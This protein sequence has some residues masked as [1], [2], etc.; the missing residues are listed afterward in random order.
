MITAPISLDE[1]HTHLETVMRDLPTDRTEQERRMYVAGVIDT[2]QETQTI[3]EGDRDAL[4]VQYV[5]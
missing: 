3:S 4:Y 1:A 2:L 5:G